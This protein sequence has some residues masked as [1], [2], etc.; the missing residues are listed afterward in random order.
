MFASIRESYGIERDDALKLRD[1]PTLNHVVGFVR[2]RAPGATAAVAAPVAPAPAPA[3]EAPS[4]PETE[5]AP[6]ASAAP[7][8]ASADDGISD[9]VLEIV[10]E[11]T[12][13]PTD[14]LDMELDLEADL[15]I[16]TVKQAEVFARIR[17]SYG[18]ERD[19]ALKLRDYP[20]LNHVVGFVR[21]R[22]P[23][24]AERSP[25]NG[26]RRDGARTRRRVAEPASR[27]QRPC[28]SPRR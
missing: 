10:A 14:L 17:E 4:A 5:P 20:T 1:Y 24:P 9:R 7:Q 27:P 2:D 23:A 18:I 16:D 6:T 3:V 28:R 11:Q 26:A 12:G 25:P 22:L 13:Y 15:G 21:D 19:D 8:A